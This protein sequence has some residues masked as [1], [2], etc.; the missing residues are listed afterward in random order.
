MKLAAT[1]V[2]HIR[3]LSA[4]RQPHVAS[5]LLLFQRECYAQ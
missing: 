3:S 5:V 4:R 2:Q 1:A